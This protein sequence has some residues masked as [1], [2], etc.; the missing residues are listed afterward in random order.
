MSVGH[1]LRVVMRHAVVGAS[2]LLPKE[3]S[4]RLERYLRGVEDHRLLQDTDAV[5]ASFGKSGRT[6]LRVLLTRYYQQRYKLPDN[7]L[8]AHD[9][10]HARDKRIPRIFFTHDNYLGDFTG[11]HEDKSPYKGHKI[12]LLVRHPAD[13]AVS[14]YHQW[15]HRMRARKK[16]INNYPVDEDMTLFDFVMGEGAGAPKIIRF[17]NAWARQIDEFE[18][19]IVVRYETL[20]ADT[21]SSLK[22]VLEF[23]DESPTPEEIADCVS[24]ASV[25]NMRAMEK[26]THFKW[27]GDRMKPGDARNP[28]SYKVRRA[29]AGGYRDDFDQ[30]QLTQI[31]ELV[32]RTLSPIYGYAGGPPDRRVI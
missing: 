18:N 20:R 9:N 16:F 5:V 31:D 6:W 4:L 12:V 24:F 32:S 22:R 23:L 14:Q 19:I 28:D 2:T 17:M 27:A 30:R 10:F 1:K 13:T 21:A 29:K 7:R 11:S 15:K 3:K 25:E 8:L 26:S